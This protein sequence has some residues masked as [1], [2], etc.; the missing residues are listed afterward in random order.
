MGAMPLV[1]RLNGSAKWRVRFAG[2]T[3]SGV[4][5]QCAMTSRP[6]KPSWSDV[7]CGAIGLL[8]VT[9]GSSAGGAQP[10]QA[11]LR[12]SPES[13]VSLAL[14]NNLNLASARRG[15]ESA[16]W[17]VRAKESVWRPTVVTTLGTIEVRRP[18]YRCA[19]CGWEYYP[20]DAHLRFGSHAV[21]WLLA[22]VLGR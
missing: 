7:R 16:D 21:S 3:R 8:I 9:C 4:R 11:A 14:A 17:N 2:G 6:A 19:A 5:D 15:P 13:A 10:S 22:K 12:V 20:H 18:R 1:F